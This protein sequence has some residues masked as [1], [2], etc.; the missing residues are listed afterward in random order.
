MKNK[1]GF[2]LI[3]LLA[4]IVILA[5]IIVIAVPQVLNVIENSRK[6]AAV[7]SAQMFVK[8]LNDS[9]Q[10]AKTGLDTS[11][12]LYSD[13]DYTVSEVKDT[14]KLKNT[15]PSDASTFTINNEKVTNACLNINGY[16]V[17]CIKRNCSITESECGSSSSTP[18]VSSPVSFSTDSW[19]TIINAVKNN[20]TSNY[21]VGDTKSI[22]MGSFG[23]HT[24]RIANKSNS[25]D[26]GMTGFSE[27]ACGFVIEFADIITN[28]RMNDTEGNVGGWPSSDLNNYM[29][30]TIFTSLPSIL[31]SNIKPTSVISGHGSSDSSNFTTSEKLYLLSPI[32]V[33]FSTS[34]VLVTTPVLWDSAEINTRTLDYY[35][36]KS[37]GT[38]SKNYGQ[39]SAVWWT[40]SNRYIYNRD[41][42]VVQTD[43]SAGGSNNSSNAFYELGVSPAFRL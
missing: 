26:C 13:K 18:E 39:T 31:Q 25:G 37:V 30:D 8:A 15:W 20:N 27:S 35:V 5:I 6:K 29:K 4:V 38:A 21:S 22:D 24:V 14:L 12:V 11:Y 9:N 19:E 34:G 16:N 1:K 2:T 33:G 41:F 28:Y 32:E 42:Y 36:G 7:E 23:T 3:E 17:S 43:G 10:I 40:R